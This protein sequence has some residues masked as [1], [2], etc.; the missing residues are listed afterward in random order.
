MESLIGMSI[1][2]YMQTSVTTK[3]LPSLAAY[4]LLEHRQDSKLE[5]DSYHYTN[6]QIK[7]KPRVSRGAVPQSKLETSQ[8]QH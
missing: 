3:P 5:P 8:C 7:T 6:T 4:K 1:D 2:G